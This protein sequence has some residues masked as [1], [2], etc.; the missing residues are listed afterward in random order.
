MKRLFFLIIVSSSLVIPALAQEVCNNGFDDDNDGFVDCYDKD[1][2]NN[3]ICKDFFIGKDAACNVKPDTF[4]PFEM[5]IKFNSPANTANHINRLIVGDVDSDGIPEI[6]TTWRNGD[7]A[8]NG[9]TASQISV[10]QAPV[11]GTTLSLD[12]KIDIFADGFKATFE[13]IAMADIDNDGCA[14]FF[15]LTS[16]SDGNGYKI[17]SYD[18]KGTKR[19]SAPIDFSTVP[20]FVGTTYPGTM[21]LVDF[22]GDGKVELYLRAMIFDAH[23]G[24]LMGQYNVDNDETNA[25]HKGVNKGWGMTSNAPIAADIDPSSPGLE[26]IAGCRIYGV[27]INRGG[28]TATITPI[29]ERSEYATRT[30]RTTGSGTSVADFNQDGYLDVLAVGS[31][32]GYDLNTTIFFWDYHN[33]KLKTYMPAGGGWGNGAGRINIAD[34]DGDTLM[35]AVYVSGS[36]L[37][38]LKETPTA[39]DILW[40]QPVTENTSGYTGCTMFDFNADGKSEI[41]YRDEDYIYIYTTTNIA[42]VVNVTRSTGITCKSR[43]SNE[44]PIVADMDGDG[45]T[46]IC[47]TCAIDETVLGRNHQL[48]DA[49]EVR[50]YQSA[51]EPWVPARRVWNQHGYFIVNVNDNLTIPTHQ[52]LSEKVFANHAPCKN[53]GRNR[54]FNSFLNQAP[55]TNSVGC[56]QY[57][58]PNL[59]PIASSLTVNVPTCPDK[60]FTISF[61]IQNTGNMAVS[62]SLPISFYNHNPMKAGATKFNTVTVTLPKL[63]PDDI[64]QVTNATVNGNGSADS[65][66]IVINDSGVPGT[67]PIK[68]PNTKIIECDYDNIFSTYIVPKPV[69]I[70]ALLVKDNVKCFG[71]SS[72]DNGA[73]RAFIP[74][75]GG[76]QN[77]ADYN[78]YW[79]NGNSA[80]PKPADF[81]GSTYTGLPQG[82]FTVYAIHKTANCNSDT[83]QA[84]VGL[85][86]KTVKDT[87]TI[88]HIVDNCKTPNGQLSASIEGGDPAANYTFDWYLGSNIFGVKFGVGSVVSGLS[89]GT[90]TALATDKATGCSGVFTASLDPISAN[91]A[92]T[93]AAVDILCN[94]AANSGSVSATATGTS[95][96]VRFSWYKGSMVKPSANFV[97][98]S[99]SPRSHGGLTAGN[100]TVVAVDSVTQCSSPPVT[101]AIKQTT[102][103]VVNATVVSNQTSCDPSLPNGSVQADVGGTTTGYSFE[104]FKGQNTLAANSVATTSTATGLAPSIYTVK[105]TDNVTGC[106]ATKEVTVKFAVVTPVL[107]LAAVGN[108]TNCTTPNGSV[109]VN[110]SIDTPADYTFFWYN[111]TTVK[112]SPDYAETSNTLTGLPVGTYTVRAVHNTKHCAAAPISASVKD[113][114]PVINIILDASVTQLPSDCTSPDGV[115]K[116]DVSAAGNVSGFN[117]KWYFGNAPFAAPPVREDDGVTSSTATGLLTGVYTV[118]ATNLDNGCVASKAFNL[119][120][121]NAQRLD[122]V[123]KVDVDKCSP[124]NIGSITVKLTKTPLAGFTEGDY[125]IFVYAGTNETGSPIETIHGVTGTLQYATSSTLTPGPYTLVAVSNNILTPGCKSVPIDTAIIQIKKDPVIG[126]AAVNANTNCTGI[127]ANGKVSLSISAPT[128]DPNDYDFNWFSGTDITGSPLAPSMIGGVNGE[129]AQNLAPGFYTVHITKKLGTGANSGCDT[130]ATY[131]IFDNPPIIS[132]ASTDISTTDVTLCTVPN[133]GS[134]TIAFVEENG[135]Q[136]AVAGY[137]FTWYDASQTP[138]GSSPSIAGLTAGTYYVVATS[139]ANN[140]AS[141]KLEFEIKDKT[142]N[143]VGVDLISFTDPT[144]CL[145]PSNITGVLDVQGTGNSTTGY[146]YAWYASNTTT[147]PIVSTNANFTGITVPGAASSV[148]YTIQVTNNSNGCQATDTY[149]LPLDVAPVTLTASAAP[150][151]S[152]RFPDGSTFSFVTSGSNNDYFYNWSFGSVVK[153]SP[154]SV[155]K[156]MIDLPAG[157]Y[158]VVAVDQFDNTCMTAPLTVTVNNAQVFPVVAAKADNPMTACDPSKADGVASAS[159]NGDIVDYRFDWYVGTVAGAPFYTGEQASNLAAVTYAVIATDIV[160]GCSDT[161]TVAITSTPKT[162]PPPQVVLLSDVTSCD[163]NDPDGSLTA[164][165]SGNPSEYIYTW[166]KTDDSSFAP[167]NSQ[168]IDHLNAGPYKL[169]IQELASLCTAEAPG[170][171]G[172]NQK[173]PDIDFT[174]VDATCNVYIEGGGSSGQPDG[175]ISLYVT[176]GVE[177]KSIEWNDNGTIVTGPILTNIDAGTYSVTVTSTKECKATKQIEVR[178]NIH[179]FNGISRNGDGKNE[180]FWINCIDNF[181]N[182]IVK[183]YNRAGTLVY[184]ATN[185]NN[186]DVVFD[187]KSNRGVS[188]MGTNLPDGTYFYII[189]KRDGSKQ[190]AGYLEIVN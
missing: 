165:V 117:I 164:V 190:L 26:L 144:R 77:T 92:V 179:P 137:T 68:L 176:N 168:I 75:S 28:M 182:N 78:F 14:E 20:G 162:I 101:I 85:T 62:G 36:T 31:N 43:T 163:P 4:P 130:T 46:E 181:P 49:A 186:N 156:E 89:P 11:S 47:V 71:S 183:I 32:G 66:F 110:V 83:T 90:Y 118:V 44:Y 151:T 178:T 94:A 172:I 160:S 188:P 152:C 114:T 93:P 88:D 112:A 154:D 153:A 150:L 149:V 147:P 6:V 35:N 57:A 42:G 7:N 148:T 69:A 102:A 58:A 86:V 73:V 104:W 132:I 52:Q 80:K 167:R 135:V 187:G 171:V 16:T 79:T 22:D 37:Y 159:V 146:S 55:F 100:Y 29:K 13:D 12:K 53:G 65:L 27:S 54:P 5:K 158:T 74:T 81:T 175:N 107:T 96:I 170:T 155:K 173:L 10:L 59:T 134:A 142:I 91:L 33:D 30:G 169:V 122:F 177:I 97:T 145:K 63:G 139:A 24:V 184:E 103:P 41:V 108:M 98:Y 106:S 82:T 64:Y 131:Q 109:S 138:I 19:W 8:G 40:T 34:I 127:T 140:C 21:G 119:P 123:S 121:A 115:M 99:T 174:V 51:N 76:G 189:D 60:D 84:V 72:P 61:K 95:N 56:P 133:G 45:S 120:F 125:D 70:T 141:T 9:T 143:T 126:A 136:V 23:T 18:C 25:P 113:A 67:T 50:I 124:T 3:T 39:L 116:V 128:T 157:N 2:Y 111:G 161:T 185:Y 48:F 15:I 17:I 129:I 1:C 105:A 166:T 38:A 180:T 87:I